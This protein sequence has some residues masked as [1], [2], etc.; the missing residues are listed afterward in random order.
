MPAWV[1]PCAD[2]PGE[3]G[4]QK[5]LMNEIDSPYSAPICVPEAGGDPRN[6]TVFFLGTRLA[7]NPSTAKG[8]H[9]QREQPGKPGTRGPFHSR[10]ARTVV[11]RRSQPP[12]A[13]V[14]VSIVG[15]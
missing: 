2:A 6:W 3:F 11:P 12:M 4:R 1:I 5:L 14:V 9:L 7:I 10:A 15:R 8:S 13:D